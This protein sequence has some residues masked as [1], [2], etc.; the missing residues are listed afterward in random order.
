M[1]SVSGSVHLR[2]R[3]VA[4]LCPFLRLS[5]SLSPSFSSAFFRDSP[6]KKLPRGEGRGGKR[7]G[8]EVGFRR[9]TSAPRNRF[10]F[11]R[12]AF[13]RPRPAFVS[14]VS[15]T[16]FPTLAFSSFIGHAPRRVTKITRSVSAS[17]AAKGRDRLLARLP[18]PLRGTLNRPGFP[19]PIKSLLS[20]ISTE[21]RQ[22]DK[23]NFSLLMKEFKAR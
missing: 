7:N 20:L 10:S 9:K 6:E 19:R 15:S 12:I 8:F 2:R 3:Q 11:Q 13:I 4:S 17:R 1:G 23:E 22:G 21:A 18:P 5:P 16:P 14:F